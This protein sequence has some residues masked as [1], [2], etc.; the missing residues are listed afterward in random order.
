MSAWLVFHRIAEGIIEEWGRR[1][2]EVQVQYDSARLRQPLEREI[3]LARQ[4]ADSIVLQRWARNP[5][6]PVLEAEAIEE[7]ESFRG[8][9][10]SRSYFVAL[11]EN[12]AVRSR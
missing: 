1:I 9:F 6:D 5:D 8:N 4:F 10:G 11:R 3:A 12:G 2:A 7:M